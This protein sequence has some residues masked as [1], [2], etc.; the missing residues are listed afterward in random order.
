MS[1]AQHISAVSKS[2][3][4]KLGDWRR[5]RNTIYRTGKGKGKGKSEHL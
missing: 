5:I 3:F 2:Y 1:F 4:R